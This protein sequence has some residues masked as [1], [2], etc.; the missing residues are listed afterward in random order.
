MY[1]LHEKVESKLTLQFGFNSVPLRVIVGS[2][3]EGL[4]LRQA[5]PGFYVSAVQVF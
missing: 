4:T 5:N 1:L 2:P 3:G